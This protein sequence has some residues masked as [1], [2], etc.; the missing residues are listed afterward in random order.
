MKGKAITINRNT[1]LCV[2]MVT[3]YRSTAKKTCIS[4]VIITINM[5]LS[6]TTIDMV[7]NERNK[8]TTHTYTQTHSFTPI[9]LYVGTAKAKRSLSR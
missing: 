2:I 3:I 1:H 4:D 8:W 9:H 6:R 7:A 5:L